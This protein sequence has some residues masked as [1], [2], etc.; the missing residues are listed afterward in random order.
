MVDITIKNVPE[1]AEQAVKNMAMV[2]IDRF[3]QQPLQPPKELFDNYKATLDNCLEA[4][5]LPKKFDV[6]IEEKIN[7]D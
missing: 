6:V 4:N 3:L 2:A 5:G 7:V 1:G